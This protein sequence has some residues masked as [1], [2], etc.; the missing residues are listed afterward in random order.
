[1]HKILA[2]SS[3]LCTRLLECEGD[4]LALQHVACTKK[5]V[6]TLWHPLMVEHVS[7]GVQQSYDAVCQSIHLHVTCEITPHSLESACHYVQ[8]HLQ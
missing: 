5:R 2:P 7:V 3:I 4:I 8:V 1:M 6:A